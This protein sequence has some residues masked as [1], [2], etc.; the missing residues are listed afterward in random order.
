MVDVL[1]KGCALEP[2]A[3]YLK[4]LG[5]LRL[6]AEQADPDARGAWRPEGFLIRSNL[7]EAGLIEFFLE[8]Y[9]PTPILTPWNGGSGFYRKVGSDALGAVERSSTR[10]FAPYRE[11]ISA[12]RA[13]LI[14]LELD[15][16]PDPSVKGPSLL[17]QLR[18]SLSD[19]ALEWFDAAVA[20]TPIGPKF[21]P[22]LGSGGNDG[23]LDFSVNQLQCLVDVL[24][25]DEGQSDHHSRSLLLGALRGGPTSGLQPGAIGQF[26]PLAA[27]GPN[28][29]SGFKRDAVANPWDYL[30][31]LEGALL[32]AAA[33][34]KRLEAGSRAGLV[35]PFM[36]SAAGVGYASASDSD[37]TTSRDEMWMPIWEQPCSLLELRSLLSEG[38]A[39]VGQRTAQTG[40][41]FALA[42]NS[43]GVGR[44]LSRF[45]RYGFE[46]RNGRSYYA[47]PHGRI[48]VRRRR[49][50]DL[51]APLDPWLQQ[52]RWKSGSDNTP[53]SI[54]RSARLLEEA[55]LDM[56]TGRSEGPLD[57]LIALGELDQALSRSRKH[58]IGP[59]PPL[60]REWLSRCDDGSV[61]FELARG[62]A[63]TGIR[64]H[65]VRVRWSTP[66]T[67]LEQDDGR[68]VWG[69]SALVPGLIATL[70]RQEI[71]SERPQK[72]AVQFAHAP[73]GLAAISA[74]VEGDTDDAKLERILRGLAIV[75]FRGAFGRTSEL[76]SPRAID[77][78]YALLTLAHRR[79]PKAGVPIP[80]TP[81]LVR[82]IA[83]GDCAGATAVAAR[84]LR[85]SG[86][87]PRVTRLAAPSARA[88]RIAAALMFP[89]SERALGALADQVLIPTANNTSHAT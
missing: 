44:G 62:L 87:S 20:L 9:S 57:V 35:Y 49:S 80:R 51:L 64:E 31:M 78:A 14:R 39:K 27:G 23:N 89:V 15:T 74:F 4:A 42:V 16:K 53:A 7:D 77:S 85:G 3:S 66:R 47:T 37:A 28:A 43:L 17:P 19:V 76:S 48:T 69:S 10:R 45:S 60:S 79:L 24:R 54:R 34:T 52:L 68:T 73:V 59:V 5:V 13:V 32:F 46:C 12:A 72:S 26:H 18:A 67:W 33:A 71:D 82:R 75:D 2:L 36:V 88:L 30:L 50:I 25:C 56:C 70:R 65:L 1:L 41:D 11:A 83:A 55:I 29:G 86:Y 21:P 8:K 61:E 38:R 6:V 81:G 22:L 58:E 40:V 63:S 84:R